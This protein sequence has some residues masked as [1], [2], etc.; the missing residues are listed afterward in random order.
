VDVQTLSERSVVLKRR[1]HHAAEVRS[2]EE[3]QLGRI[4]AQDHRGL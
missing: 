1:R 4:P 3:V 2:G